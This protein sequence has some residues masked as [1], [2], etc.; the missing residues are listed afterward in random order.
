[1]LEYVKA[2]KVSQIPPNS[3]HCVELKGVRIALYNIAGTFYATQD[4]CT[5]ADAPLSEGHVEGCEVICPWHGAR[6]D[7]TNGR[8]VG[9]LAYSDLATF[10]VRV[11]GDDVEIEI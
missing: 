10:K 2:A 1:M 9:E 5:H 8:G 6:F 7:V 4:Y 3:A 11:V